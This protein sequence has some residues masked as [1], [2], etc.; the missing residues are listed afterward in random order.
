MSWKCTI[1][2]LKL[3][4]I[5]QT[6]EHMLKEHNSYQ[7]NPTKKPTDLTIQTLN[8]LRSVKQQVHWLLINKPECKGSDTLLILE[9]LK[10]FQDFLIYTPES[11]R[12]SFKDPRGVTYEQFLYMQSWETVRRCRQKLQE[13]DRKLYHDKEGHIIGDHQC[14]LASERVSLKRERRE[15][16][17]HDNIKYL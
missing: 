11:Q 17:I 16:V 1:C 2:G 10:Y 3:T 5:K 9:H 13:T 8:S 6:K 4:S 15:A 7:D 14:L 12:I